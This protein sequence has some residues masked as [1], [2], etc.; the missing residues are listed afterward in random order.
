[1]EGAEKEEQEALVEYLISLGDADIKDPSLEISEEDLK[2]YLGKYEF[3]TG[4]DE[5]FEVTVN[6]QGSLFIGRGEYSGRSLNM[7]DTHQFA[8]NGAP[9]VRVHFDVVNGT[10]TTLT[11]HDPVP[12]VKAKRVS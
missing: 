6:S 9:S 10:A 4:A 3:G 7:R 1:M 2:V 5:Y 8:P 12:I 11:I